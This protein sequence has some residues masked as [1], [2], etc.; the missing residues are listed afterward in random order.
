MRGIDRRA[1]LKEGARALGITAVA[2]L[3]LT[4]PALFAVF[5]GTDDTELSDSAS[6]YVRAHAPAL[7]HSHSLFF[8]FPFAAYPPIMAYY[9]PARVLDRILP[10]DWTFPALGFLHLVV[11]GLGMHATSRLA[12]RTRFFPAVLSSLL[13]MTCGFF[14][15]RRGQSHILA[16]AAWLPMAL[17]GAALYLRHRRPLGLPIAVASLALALLAGHYQIVLYGSLMLGVSA[18][19]FSSRPGP[20]AAVALGVPLLAALLAGM[21][22][23]PAWDFLHQGARDELIAAQFD[24]CSFSFPDF[25]GFLVPGAFGGQY[26]YLFTRR[27]AGRWSFHEEACYVGLAAT[28]LAMAYLISRRR[29]GWRARWLLALLGVGLF[30]ALGHYNP[31]YGAFRYVPGFNLFR[32]PSRALLLVEIGVALAAALAFDRWQLRCDARAAVSRAVR[33]TSAVTAIGVAALMLWWGYGRTR[34]WQQEV[35]DAE[36]RPWDVVARNLSASSHPHTP[37]L[38]IPLALAGIGW[39]F[40]RRGPF[41]LGSLILVDAFLFAYC[42]RTRYPENSPAERI[43]AKAI[44]DD[45]RRRGWDPGTIRVL[46]DVEENAYAY[47]GLASVTGLSALFPKELPELV[48]LKLQGVLSGWP[49]A[50]RLPDLG[51][52]YVVSSGRRLPPFP[53][54]A[55]LDPVVPGQVYAVPSAQPLV[56]PSL[57]VTWEPTRIAATLPDGVSGAV[58]ILCRWDP[59]WRATVDGRQV[60]VDRAGAFMRVQA[61]PGDRTLELT[62][63]NP[64][65]RNG[66]RVTAVGL[67]VF[68]ALS[69]LSA[70]PGRVK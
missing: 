54:S 26:G 15:A 60:G 39:A 59:S 7:E 57:S 69:F 38:L 21:G 40:A 63:D 52:S 23:L 44:L 64:A 32:V 42:I 67:A 50:E 53:P 13:L 17:A 58:D 46:A 3:L 70:R 49:A 34:N 5:P 12:L 22:M 41:A 11:A 9:P 10:S 28:G 35:T 68:L 25:L 47:H 8:G 61:R 66:R 19:F 45:A 51:I 1:I 30:I 24:A 14:S 55:L 29:H 43:P 56:R 27:Y 62:Y 31:L 18:L 2:A 4:L 36:P 16:S 37:R 20:V 65:Y 48:P 6:A 33:C